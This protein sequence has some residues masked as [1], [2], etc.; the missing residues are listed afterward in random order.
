[1]WLLLLLV[2]LS[3]ELNTKRSMTLFLL[4]ENG[5]TLF[6]WVQDLLIWSSNLAFSSGQ[7]WLFSLIM[8]IGF[9]LTSFKIW[10]VVVLC[11]SVRKLWFFIFFSYIYGVSLFD[12]RSILR[13]A[14][15]VEEWTMYCDWLLCCQKSLVVS[16]ACAEFAIF[17]DIFTVLDV[18]RWSY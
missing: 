14:L 8:G 12:Y 13:E 5:V 7:N 9:L 17:E 6:I 3:I 1:M 10:L 16:W 2:C 18:L 15:N 4:Q 11:S